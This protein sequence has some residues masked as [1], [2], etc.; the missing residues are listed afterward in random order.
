VKKTNGRA[1]HTDLTC[2]FCGCLA[3]PHP[4]G[5]SNFS[6]GVRYDQWRC[7]VCS[8]KLTLNVRTGKWSFSVNEFFRE[9]VSPR[10]QLIELLASDAGDTP[11]AR[12]IVDALDEYLSEDTGRIPVRIVAAV[13]QQSEI[14]RLRAERD[15]AIA[16][17]VPSPPLVSEQLRSA[18]AIV[19]STFDVAR[20][21]LRGSST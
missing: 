16:P 4:D 11:R 6:D 2:P 10:E 3:E 8:H 20:E 15:A 7:S 14:G 18:V 12:A 19:R 9:T 21:L 1:P 5:Q 17:H 13:T